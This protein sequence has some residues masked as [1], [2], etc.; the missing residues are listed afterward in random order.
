VR[1]PGRF[2]SSVRTAWFLCSHKVQE[3]SEG[4][5]RRFPGPW[6]ALIRGGAGLFV[7]LRSLPELCEKWRRRGR[8]KQYALPTG[9]ACRRLHRQPTGFAVRPQQS[10]RSA[11]SRH[12]IGKSSRAAVNLRVSSADKFTRN[13]GAAGILARAVAPGRRTRITEDPRSNALARSAILF[14]SV[15]LRGFRLSS[16]LKSRWLA[17]VRMPVIMS[18]QH[19]CGRSSRFNP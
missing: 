15:A 17:V 16:V 9:H 1:D 5:Q 12:L 4:S 6:T 8:H 2:A 3:A 7:N 11:T 14:C 19:H 13:R 10:G 18:L